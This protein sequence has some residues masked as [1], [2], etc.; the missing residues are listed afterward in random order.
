MEHLSGILVGLLN[1][2]CANRLFVVVVVVVVGGGGLFVP[3]IKVSL[4]EFGQPQGIA[5]LLVCLS[6]LFSCYKKPFS[7]Y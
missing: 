7:P 6:N 5:P 3:F 1:P 4:V 2:V